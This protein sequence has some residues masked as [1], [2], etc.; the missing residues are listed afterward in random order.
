VP[1]WMCLESLELDSSERATAAVHRAVLSALLGGCC[2]VLPPY[3]WACCI[4]SKALLPLCAPPPRGARDEA[5]FRRLL[6]LSRGDL[7]FPVFAFDKGKISTRAPRLGAA[8]VTRN[9]R[10]SDAVAQSY[11]I[12]NYED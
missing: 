10:R 3:R 2:C 8:G 5:Q 7:A 11:R 4:S 9:L 12:I 1:T 6:A